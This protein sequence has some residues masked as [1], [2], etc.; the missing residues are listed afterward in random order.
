[1]GGA[2]IVRVRGQFRCL[3]V[4]LGQHVPVAPVFAVEIF[5]ENATGN[6]RDGWLQKEIKYKIK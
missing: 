3:R 1:M 6:A 4:Q 5:E 2:A